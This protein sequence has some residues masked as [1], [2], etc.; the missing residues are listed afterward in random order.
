[1]SEYVCSICDGTGHTANDADRPWWC[2]KIERLR[3]SSDPEAVGLELGPPEPGDFVEGDD[4]AM[5][6]VTEAKPESPTLKRLERSIRSRRHIEA[7]F[8]DEAKPESPA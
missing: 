2:K 5:F 1:M 3:G 6:V 4:G 7:A 8:E